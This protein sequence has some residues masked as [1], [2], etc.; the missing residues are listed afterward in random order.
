MFCP[1]SP[2]KISQV[3]DV[4]GKVH[5]ADKV[6]TQKMGEAE[7]KF[8]KLKSDSASQFDKT[9]KETGRE[10]SETIDNFDKTVNKKTSEAKSGLSS[11][12][13]FGK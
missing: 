8:D 9:K 10:L 7:S 11:W 1:K 3:N 12:F 6:I 2:K 4:R 5:E 13:G